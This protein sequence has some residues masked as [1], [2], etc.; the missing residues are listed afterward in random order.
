VLIREMREVAEK[1]SL[2]GV[3]LCD[4]VSPAVRAMVEQEGRTEGWKVRGTWDYTGW[5]EDCVIYLGPGYMEAFTR[6]KLHL[7]VVLFWD[8]ANRTGKGYYE[9]F[10]A[11]LQLAMT[12]GL[13]EE[14]ASN[15]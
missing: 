7:A 3:I 1:G 13:L 4:D 2:P 5:E 6:A 9:E 8:P 11:A 12:E 10:S 15:N 14:V